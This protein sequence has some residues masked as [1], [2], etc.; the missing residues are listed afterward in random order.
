MFDLALTLNDL[1]KISP[2]DVHT[3][4]EYILEWC[5][6]NLTVSTG[7]FTVPTIYRDWDKGIQFIRFYNEEDA[8]LFKLRWL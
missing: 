6:E 2:N 5:S 1:K 8:M 3:L 7:F 4:H